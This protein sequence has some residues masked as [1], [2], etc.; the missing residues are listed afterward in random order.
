MKFL[1]ILFIS[2]TPHQGP[3]VLL[4]KL[5]I[6]TLSDGLPLGLIAQQKLG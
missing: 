4:L 2:Q 3:T 1:Y 5:T 6:I